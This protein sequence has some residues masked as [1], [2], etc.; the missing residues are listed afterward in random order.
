MA[1]RDAR[2]IA[3]VQFKVLNLAANDTRRARRMLIAAFV[4][5]SKDDKIWASEVL[6]NEGAEL[7]GL[8]EAVH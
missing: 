6:L 3:C 7:A 1:H 5:L 2:E 4:G 8:V